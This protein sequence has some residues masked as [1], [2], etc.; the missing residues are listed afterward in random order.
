M[1]C[2]E[3]FR[4]RKHT[5]PALLQK[6][7]AFG[8]VGDDLPLNFHPAATGARFVFTPIGAG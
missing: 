2:F 5:V 7:A 1:D 3:H 6:D 8:Q 4:S